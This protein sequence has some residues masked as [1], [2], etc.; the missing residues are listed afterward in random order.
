MPFYFDNPL[1]NP[2]ALRALDDTKLLTLIRSGA[3][4]VNKEWCEDNPVLHCFLANENFDVVSRFFRLC[5]ERINPNLC[6]GKTF[7]NK[8]LLITLTLVVSSGTLPIDFINRYQRELNFDYQDAEGK[9]A[10][11]Y[12]VILGRYDIVNALIAAGASVKIPDR[13]GLRALDYIKCSTCLVSK[14]LKSIDIE[15][16]R[17]RKAECNNLKDHSGMNLMLQ[18]AYLI[19]KKEIIKRIL[20]EPRL[21]LIK[22]IERGES[23]NTFVGDDTKATFEEMSSFAENIATDYSYSLS[24]VFVNMRLDE[25][26]NINFILYLR[27][28][29]E[30]LSGVS[31]IDECL[32]GHRI[33]QEILGKSMESKLVV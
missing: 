31:V 15:P 21:S 6:D 12:A 33:L 23:W 3:F 13:A 9:T 26:E 18:G 27:G 20:D 22:Y 32:A 25:A 28:L 11:H 5:P 14:T 19:Q 2:S 29:Y 17:D 4:N 10:L 7:G 1:F 16:T 8:S 24:D 30:K